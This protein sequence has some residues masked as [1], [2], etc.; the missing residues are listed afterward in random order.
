MPDN[1]SL[2]Q[3]IYCYMVTNS[4]DKFI[5]DTWNIYSSHITLFIKVKKG[6]ELLADLIFEWELA[7]MREKQLERWPSLSFTN[8]GVKVENFWIITTWNIL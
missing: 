8:R 3:F 2:D 4:S 5:K 1:T 6:P 7:D